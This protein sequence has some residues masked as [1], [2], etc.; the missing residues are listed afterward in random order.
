MEG[1][2]IG[3]CFDESVGIALRIGDH[4]MNIKNQV[5]LG[6]Y[7]LNQ[8]GTEADIRHEMSVHNIQVQ[9]V[10]TRLIHAPDFI[11][12]AGVTRGKQ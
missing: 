6:T 12:E 8:S 5:G 4:Q 1:D 2:N 3:T 11:T 7:G 10:C 9:V